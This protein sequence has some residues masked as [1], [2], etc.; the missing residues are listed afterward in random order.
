MKKY[1]YFPIIKTRDAELKALSKLSNEYFDKTLPIYELTKSRKANI[2]PDGDI[3]RRMQNI[4]EV[5]G[6]RPF[7]L[8]LTSND[9]YLNEQIRQLVD[10]H[11][12]YHEWRYFINIYNELNIIPMIHIYDDLDF[13]EV[14]SFVYKMSKTKNYLA[15]RLPLNLEEHDKFIKP[16][17]DA[18]DDNCSLF[19]ILDAGQVNYSNKDNTQDLFI[20]TCTSLEKFHARTERIIIASTSFPSSP[21]NFGNYNEGS[22]P[23]VEEAIYKEVEKHYPV[24]YGD[25]ASINIEQIEMKGGT[26]V[27]RIDIALDNEFIYKRHRRDAGSYSMCAKNILADKRYTPMDIWADNEIL[28][29]AK[30]EPSG[31]SPS[32]WI[33]VRMNYF[34]SSRV[35][36]RSL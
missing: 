1:I 25:Y 15:V 19:I 14:R 29:A 21:A 8:D 24:G 9:K 11:D 20:S 35:K 16:I 26:F 18:L 12:G 17:I 7:I 22:F 23:I 36:L 2:A 10:E 6:A 30:G 34:M 4:K 27:P 33:A 31:I 5:Q 32:F 13:T 3:H 28:L